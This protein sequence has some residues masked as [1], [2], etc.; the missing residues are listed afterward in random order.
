M[1]QWPGLGDAAG[2]LQGVCQA[3]SQQQPRGDL[4]APRGPVVYWLCVLSPRAC[5]L[6][7]RAGSQTRVQAS[8][9]SGATKQG[10]ALA[11]TS[12]C[13]ARCQHSPG[14]RARPRRGWSVSLQ[15]ASTSVTLASGCLLSRHPLGWGRGCGPLRGWEHRVRIFQLVRHK[16]RAV[17]VNSPRAV[18]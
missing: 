13:V 16:P 7:G 15:L 14:A 3:P 12:A 18:V 8:P 11:P 1:G 9:R 6:V 4:E 5:S 2:S 17:R 10:L